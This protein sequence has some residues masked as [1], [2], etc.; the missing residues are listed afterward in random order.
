MASLQQATGQHLSGRYTV[1]VVGGAE[2]ALPASG[3]RIGR[4]ADNGLILPETQVSRH[5][6]TVWEQ[7]GRCYV[8]DEGSTNGTSVNGQRLTGTSEVRCGDSIAIGRYVLQIDAASAGSYH[9]Q[10][11]MARPAGAASGAGV[12]FGLALVLLI[13][14]IVAAIGT[15]RQAG[16]GLDLPAGGRDTPSA[17][18]TVPTVVGTPAT[19]P[20][21]AARSPTI[22]T[23]VPT[24]NPV[25]RAASAVVRIEV[26]ADRNSGVSGSGSVVSKSGYI[27]TN[28]HVVV[29]PRTN[30]PYNEQG[31]I[32]IGIA[33]SF[34]QL[35]QNRY[36]A[37]VV[38]GDSDLDLA[39]L[40]IR[41]TISGGA[42]P[43]D[44]GLT[45]AAIGDSD[46]L[47]L[48][49]T[50]IVI[51]FPGLANTVTVTGG[52]VSGFEP[53]GK[54]DRAWIKTDASLAPG[55]SGGLAI[56]ENGEMVGVPSIVVRSEDD[57]TARIGGIRPINLAGALLRLVK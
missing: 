36:L 45:T 26:P 54:H 57:G 24:H 1:R 49:D 52:R 48:G 41:A 25:Q 30:R 2:H 31:T 23:A 14:G 29:N 43:R 15:T 4:T 28:L 22:V 21:A 27:L 32:R 9:P 51:G 53:E 12:A 11:A 37:E 46:T 20:T 16:H 34:G 50:L 55:N 17:L 6:A 8:R 47:A 18:P 38:S 13:L 3:L 39:L 42:L 44:L 40:R 10:G 7:G 33:A 35:P 56:N 19:A 5:H